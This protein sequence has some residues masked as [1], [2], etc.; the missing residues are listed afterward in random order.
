V[1]GKGWSKKIRQELKIP[2]LECQGLEDINI[3][4]KGTGVIEVSPHLYRKE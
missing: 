3:E 2:S 1:G 4:K